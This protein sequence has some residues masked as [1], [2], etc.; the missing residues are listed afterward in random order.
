MKTSNGVAYALARVA[1]SYPNF[2]YLHKFPPCIVDLIM[3]EIPW[4][5]FCKKN[6]K[7]TYE[8]KIKLLVFP[9]FQK[10]LYLVL[11][12]CCCQN[13]ALFRLESCWDEKSSCATF[14]GGSSNN[15]RSKA[16]FF[17]CW[18]RCQAKEECD[19]H[20]QHLHH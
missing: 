6:K 3:N 14:G 11:L 4:V 2:Q 9:S 10:Q 18:R 20:Q 13:V 5:C 8:H 19:R 15:W 7:K 17:M 1:P 16:N 12:I